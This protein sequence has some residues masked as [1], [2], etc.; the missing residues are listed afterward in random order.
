VVPFAF[1][2]SLIS[3]R[4]ARQISLAALLAGL[5]PACKTMSVADNQGICFPGAGVRSAACGVAASAEM[6]AGVTAGKPVM[7]EALAQLPAPQEAVR[8]AAAVHPFW[9]APFAGRSEGRKNQLVLPPFMRGNGDVTGSTPALSAHMDPVKPSS[10]ASQSVSSKARRTVTLHEAV[11]QA[12]LTFPE[13]RAS[14]AR[15][16]EAKASIAMAQAGLYPQ[17]DLRLASGGSFGGNAVGKSVYE[18][19]NPDGNGRFDGSLSFKQL[20]YDF[21]AIRAD[22]ERTSYIRD[23]EQLKLLDKVDEVVLKTAQAYLKVLENRALLGLVD[24]T[25]AAHRKL[26]GIVQANQREGNGTAADVNRVNSRLTDMHAIRSDVSLQLAGA[27]EQ[28]QRLTKM[29]PAALSSAPV[30]RGRLPKSSAEAIMLMKRNNPRLGSLNATAQS[31][32]K[33]LEFQRLSQLPKVQL[34]IDSDSKNYAALNRHKNE[35]EARALITMRYRFMDGGLGKATLDQLNHRRES[36]IYLLQNEAEQTS[37]DIRQAYRAVDSALLKERLVGEGVTTSAKVMELYLEQ[38]KA[39]RRT[40]FEL[41]DSQMSS[42]TVRR[43]QIESRYEGQRATFEILRH[44]GRLAEAMAQ[45][46]GA[47][48]PQP[49]P[50]AQGADRSRASIKRQTVSSTAP[51]DRKAVASDPSGDPP[52]YPVNP[53]RM[54]RRIDES[55]LKKVLS[56]P[57][58]PAAA[59]SSARLPGA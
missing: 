41:L 6:T 36:S 40:V 50:R 57:A 23:A 11:T 21:G 34:E 7:T 33:E 51:A 37:A 20:I 32:Q 39:G 42:F 48:P 5:V 46:T 44:S 22:I 10:L 17:G 1:R 29:S 43:S 12:V 8:T 9:T 19:A 4:G 13:I 25:V 3:L 54:P 59:F 14:E 30:L 18:R 38:F 35:S 49:K 52:T 24:E 28:F 56:T 53:S 2:P 58:E 26:A 47:G 16:R 55:H 31:I 27:E 15:V 45:A